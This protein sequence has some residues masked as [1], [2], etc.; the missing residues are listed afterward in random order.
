ML[1]QII[2]S[3]KQALLKDLAAKIWCVSDS[4]EESD[5]WAEP[6][7]EALKILIDVCYPNQRRRKVI[8]V[9]LILCVS[10]MFS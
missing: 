1:I 4:G 6:N 8:P 9:A 3:L 5:K 10:E 2:S 7:Q